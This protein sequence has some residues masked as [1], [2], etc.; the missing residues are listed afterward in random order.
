MPN[1]LYF[2]P[3][4]LRQEI[5]RER[6]VA[7]GLGDVLRDRLSRDDLANKGRLAIADVIHGPDATQGTIVYP[8]PTTPQDD[9][10]NGIGYYPAT[11]KWRHI[12]ATGGAGYWVGWDPENL[13]TPEA[14]ERETLISGYL[15]ELGDGGFWECP[16]IRL[17]HGGFNLPDTW[18]LQDGKV[19]ARVKKNWQ[20]AWDLSG[21]IWD[22]LC[23]G[24]D[25]VREVAYSW[26]AKLLSINYRVGLAEVEILD[27]LGT[28]EATT[29]LRAAI[30]GPFIE[31]LREEQKKRST[32]E[33]DNQS[34]S[35]PGSADSIPDS[36]PVAQTST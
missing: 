29:I 3:K 17:V 16:I 27:L 14:L 10:A 9:E 11:Q 5:N 15:E 36:A 13:P 22:Q 28:N 23:S 33:T 18:G 34:T 6:I 21:E 32:P 25:P 30:N 24:S 26:C 4:T 20:W 8:L 7:A 31:K 12:P 1:F 19:V 2:I 35:S